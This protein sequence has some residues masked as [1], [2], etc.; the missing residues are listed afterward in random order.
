MTSSNRPLSPHLQ[1]YRLPLVALLSILHRA[2]GVALVGGA[3]LLVYWL[4]SAAYGPAAYERASALLGSFLGRLVLLGFTAALYYHLC[5][6]I[7]H[8][9]W[10]VGRGYDLATA[11]R[12]GRL[13]IAAAALLT[14][15]T[16]AIGLSS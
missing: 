13:V 10:D 3:L 11:N 5:N 8:L 15:L 6:G 9:F 7:R 1:I 4:G 2:T 14:V 16:W 12:S